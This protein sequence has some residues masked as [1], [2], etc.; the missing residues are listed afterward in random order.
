MFKISLMMADFIKFG[1]TLHQ[2]MNFSQQISI[3]P[4]NVIVTWE[5]HTVEL[6]QSDT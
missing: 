2:P 5:T 4:N 3:I 1:K 6:V